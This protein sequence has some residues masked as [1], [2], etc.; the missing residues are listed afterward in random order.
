MSRNRQLA[1]L[2]LAMSLLQA[3]LTPFVVFIKQVLADVKD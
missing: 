1:T 2:I 3:E